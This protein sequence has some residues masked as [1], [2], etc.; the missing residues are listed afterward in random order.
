MVNMHATGPKVRRFK[1]GQGNG[2][3]TA[4]EIHSMP[5]FG[6]EL[7]PEAAL[8]KISQYVKYIYVV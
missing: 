3:L 8:C 7:N 4:I 2:F 5:S 6:G 1:P